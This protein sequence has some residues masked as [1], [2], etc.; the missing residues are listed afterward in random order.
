MDGINSKQNIETQIA[1]YVYSVFVITIF[2]YEKYYNDLLKNALK[3][4]MSRNDFWYGESWEDYFL[5][6]EAYYEKLHEQTHIQGYYNFVAFNTV[7]HN[8]F[9]DKKKGDKPQNYPTSSIYQ[10]SKEKALEGSKTSKKQNVRVTK[11]NLQNVY[12]NRLANV[13]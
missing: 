13:W 6:E 4:G 11:E 7:L 10:E 1:L 2:D 3:Y 9:L 12:M 5:Y 8:A